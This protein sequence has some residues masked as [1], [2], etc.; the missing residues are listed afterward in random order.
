M[1]IQ[2]INQEIQEM[3]AEV[4][5]KGWPTR[6]ENADLCMERAAEYLDRRDAVL[7]KYGFTRESFK[8]AVLGTKNG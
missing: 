5:A 4:E 3:E 2:K 6:A 7:A 1:N 8:A